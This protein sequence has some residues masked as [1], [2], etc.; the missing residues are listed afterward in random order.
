MQNKETRA[1]KCIHRLTLVTTSRHQVLCRFKRLTKEHNGEGRGEGGKSMNSKGRK[2]N[3]KEVGDERKWHKGEK[4]EWT[5]F[6]F[7]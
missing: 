1:H 5:D 3:K 2:H 7:F 4:E 6:F